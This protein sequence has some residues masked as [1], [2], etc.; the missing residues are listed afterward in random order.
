MAYFCYREGDCKY[1]NKD[2][3]GIRVD[4]DNYSFFMRLNPN[5]HERNLFCNCFEKE[6]VDRYLERKSLNRDMER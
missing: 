6:K 5:M 4:A 1:N 2:E 3:Y